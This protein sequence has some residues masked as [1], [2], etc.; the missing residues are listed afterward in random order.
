VFDLGAA[1]ARA[2]RLRFRFVSGDSIADS[3]WEIARVEVIDA[4]PGTG[5][6]IVLVA[7]PN[8]VRGSTRIAFRITGPLTWG[9]RPTTL[10]VYDV[11][12]RL[13]RT[14]SHAPVPAANGFVVWDGT[15]HAGRV[16]ASGVYVARLDWGGATATRRLV[17]VR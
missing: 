6:D 13:V 15:D 5:H 9:A 17:V 12:G 10:A 14:L 11:R 2:A 4:P 1:P 7:E 3:G 8:P 16:V